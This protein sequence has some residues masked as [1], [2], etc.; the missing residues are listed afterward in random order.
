MEQ[1][2]GEA[3]AA[4]QSK[5]QCVRRPTSEKVR[6]PTDALGAIYAVVRAVPG[7]PPDRK[8][9]E[10]DLRL[11]FFERY[12]AR[13]G[14]AEPNIITFLSTWAMLAHLWRRNSQHSIESAEGEGIRDG[15]FR[16]SAV[17]GMF[18]HNI[19]VRKPG[20]AAVKFA[21][22]GIMPACRAHPESRLLP[23]L[24]QPPARVRASTWWKLDQQAIVGVA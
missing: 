18:R 5:A 2:P 20:P 4:R 24:P 22:G 6:P 23:A 13:L 15:V 17:L 10:K 12:R 11:A 9:M 19:E 8:P 16:L 7:Q 21:V 3:K 14:V 1:A